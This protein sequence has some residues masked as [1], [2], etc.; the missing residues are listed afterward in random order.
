MIELSPGLRVGSNIDVPAPGG[1]FYYFESQ[2]QLQGSGSAEL[3]GYLNNGELPFTL[4]ED[5][6][7]RAQETSEKLCM[8]LTKGKGRWIQHSGRESKGCVGGGAAPDH[9]FRAQ[10]GAQRRACALTVLLLP[11]SALLSSALLWT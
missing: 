9:P 8:I 7:R 2:L 11:C 6:D 10:G 3:Q 4:F 1:A 5:E